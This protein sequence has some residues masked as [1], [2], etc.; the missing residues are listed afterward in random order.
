M[1][2][3][4]D[5]GRFHDGLGVPGLEGDEIRLDGQSVVA[6]VVAV[7]LLASEL[8]LDQDLRWTAGQ[9]VSLDYL[10]VAPDVGAHELSA[11]TVPIPGEPTTLRILGEGERID[12]VPDPAS[13]GSG[14][15]LYRGDL[16]ALRADDQH[17]L[18]CV[19]ADLAGPPASDP[20]APTAAAP[21]YWLVSAR[22]CAG[23]SGLGSDSVGT[24]RSNA[25][26]PCP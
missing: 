3:V 16:A 7:D 2:A 5:A 8:T 1:L 10:G 6:R 26:T 24:Q 4:A 25:G 17:V 23:E 22:S 15:D 9:G 18:T 20:T 14:F 13:P 11:C 21:L 19:Q 12:F